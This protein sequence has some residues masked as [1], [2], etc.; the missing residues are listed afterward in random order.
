MFIS[1]IE[2]KTLDS[3]SFDLARTNFDAVF[4]QLFVNFT[5]LRHLVS[6]D[7]Q[8]PRLFNIINDLELRLNDLALA[9]DRNL[10][11]FNK[12]GLKDPNSSLSITKKDMLVKLLDQ[13]NESNYSC[14]ILRSI[15]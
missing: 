10:E 5:K 7:N 11:T 15:L 2:L 12:F 14:S 6:R 3:S 9:Y 13:Y 4:D 8:F 1:N